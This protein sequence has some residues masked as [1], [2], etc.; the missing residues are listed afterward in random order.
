MWP[1]CESGLSVVQRKAPAGPD[2]VDKRGAPTDAESAGA[3]EMGE[4]A[5]GAQGGFHLFFT[6]YV[7]GVL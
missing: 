2:P 6:S 4:R 7:A 3:R 5:D 1:P